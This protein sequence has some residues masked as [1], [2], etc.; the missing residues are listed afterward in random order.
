MSKW[1]IS[2]RGFEIGIEVSINVNVCIFYFW[3]IFVF[4]AIIVDRRL[5]IE[6]KMFKERFLIIGMYFVKSIIFYFFGEFNICF[7][8]FKCFLF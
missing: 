3:R 8:K 4:K 1:K 7:R 5:F 6:V 2:E